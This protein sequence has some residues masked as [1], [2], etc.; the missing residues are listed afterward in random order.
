MSITAHDA[1]MV[2]LPYRIC[3][4]KL[5]HIICTIQREDLQKAAALFQTV[6]IVTDGMILVAVIDNGDC[7]LD[8]LSDGQRE[9]AFRIEH[10]AIQI[11][12]SRL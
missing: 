1:E 8:L 4:F 10:Q 7:F 2:F 11:I 9:L 3:F 6:Q 5:Y 12:I